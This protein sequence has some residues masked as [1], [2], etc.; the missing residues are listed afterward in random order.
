MDLSPFLFLIGEEESNLVGI[1]IEFARTPQD[2]MALIEA[3]ESKFH[4]LGLPLEFPE[5]EQQVC[6][7]KNCPAT[8]MLLFCSEFA[9]LLIK[10]IIPFPDQTALLHVGGALMRSVPNRRCNAKES[11]K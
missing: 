4:L 10:N 2:E 6:I 9:E 7:L 1:Q 3:M 8:R 11:T 5:K